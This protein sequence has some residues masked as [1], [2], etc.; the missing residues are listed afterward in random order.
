MTQE[1]PKV[2]Q[3]DYKPLY[4]KILVRRAEAESVSKGG[5]I[6]PEAAKRKTR[7]GKVLAVGSGRVLEDGQIRPLD[8]KVGD[9]VFFRGTSG[10]E[11]GI[12]GETLVML[13]EDDV[14]AVASE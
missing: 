3:M 2:T 14:E 7:H 10:D 13:K 8:V 5:I 6:I 11:V 4:D 9:I 12:D 1:T